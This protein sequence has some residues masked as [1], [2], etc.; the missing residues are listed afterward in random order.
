MALPQNGLVR[1]LQ[2]GAMD[3]TVATSMCHMSCVIC[4]YHISNTFFIG[5]G[6]G[7]AVING[8]HP[9]KLNTKIETIF[10]YYNVY[11]K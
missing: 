1:L 2:I 11:C 6:G 10:L 3:F 7:G 4:P 8:G 9:V 5:H